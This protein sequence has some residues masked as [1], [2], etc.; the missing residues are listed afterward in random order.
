MIDLPL[1]RM[2]KTPHLTLISLSTAM[3]LVP[4]L[5]SALCSALLAWRG[6]GGAASL[7]PVHLPLARLAKMAC[8]GVLYAAGPKYQLL[9]ALR[10]APGAALFIWPKYEQRERG[11]PVFRPF[12]MALL[13]V[14][15]AA[16]VWAAVQW[17]RGALK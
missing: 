4:Y 7:R 5:F 3:I 6:E 15:V 11:L 10:Y 14:L 8:A 17:S 1:T 12:E 13:G 2:S 9:S 16:A